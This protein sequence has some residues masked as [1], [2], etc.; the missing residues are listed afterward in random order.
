M[1]AAESVIR[2][3]S[4]RVYFDREIL[5][6][7]SNKD[8][9]IGFLM[10]KGILANNMVCS[11]CSTHMTLKEYNNVDGC[12]WKCINKTCTK[13]GTTICIRRGSCF[14]GRRADLRKFIHAIYLWSL[15]INEKEVITITGL[16]RPTMVIIFGYLR[17]ICGRYFEANPIRLGGRGAICQVDE[18]LFCGRRKN[19]TGRVTPEQWVFGIADTST[20]PAL[21]YMECVGRRDRETLLPIIER[22]CLPGTTIVSDGWAAYPAIQERGFPFMW[23]N[24]RVNFVNPLNGAHTQH[25]ESYWAKHKS[26][27]RS[28]HGVPRERLPEYLHELMWRERHRN[29]PFEAILEDIKRYH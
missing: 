5:P 10:G 29:A 16:S 15:G 14:E 18:S 20:T 9:A 23:V 24:H 12:R 26:V 6:L 11:F 2:S 22:M 28:M 17:I 8:A 13:R 25:I 4:D 21:G 7:L 1:S 19:N 27:L 3:T